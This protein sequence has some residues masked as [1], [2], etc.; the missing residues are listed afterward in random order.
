MCVSKDCLFSPSVSVWI[1]SF[2][3]LL[4]LTPIWHFDGS[5]VLQRVGRTVRRKLND[6][7]RI[8][9]ANRP[10]LGRGYWPRGTLRNSRGRRRRALQHKLLLRRRLLWHTPHLQ[11][12]RPHYL[13]WLMGVGIG[14][15]LKK[16]LALTLPNLKNLIGFHVV[17]LLL[18]GLLFDIAPGG[19]LLRQLNVTLRSLLKH[20][21]LSPRQSSSCSHQSSNAGNR[22][23]AGSLGLAANNNLLLG[24]GRNTGASVGQADRQ[25]DRPCHARNLQLNHVAGGG[26]VTHR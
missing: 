9:L 21:G 2:Q 12:L 17:L 14:R 6:E 22:R 16:H 15:H 25:G 18:P 19:R 3:A 7:R 10:R 1:W 11:R 24:L 5:R 20:H 26:D 13:D 8:R 23:L 4:P